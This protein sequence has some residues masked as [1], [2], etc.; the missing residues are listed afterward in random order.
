MVDTVIG[1]FLNTNKDAESLLDKL[2][3]LYSIDGRI[4]IEKAKMVLEELA[5]VGHRLGNLK[6][7]FSYKKHY[8]VVSETSEMLAKKR[9]NHYPFLNIEPNKAAYFGLVEEH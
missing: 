3:R 4:E 1:E 5:E 6:N 2:F 8:T 7:L 9:L